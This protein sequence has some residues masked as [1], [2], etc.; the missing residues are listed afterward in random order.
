MQ[1]VGT[2]S[3]VGNSVVLAARDPKRSSIFVCMCSYD[4]SLISMIMKVKRH[5][6]EK[7]AREVIH[8]CN[9]QTL[10]L[11]RPCTV[12][13]IPSRPQQT[14]KLD[15]ITLDPGHSTFHDQPGDWPVKMN[16]LQGAHSLGLVAPIDPFTGKP[17]RRSANMQRYIEQ[18]WQ[19][20]AAGERAVAETKSA[21]LKAAQQ[22]AAEQ[23][24]TKRKAEA[25][26]KLSDTGDVV[27]HVSH[28]Y[29]T[30]SIILISYWKV[31]TGSTQCTLNWLT[32]YEGSQG[33]SIS[34]AQA[35]S[36]CPNA[37]PA[38]YDRK[39][40]RTRYTGRFDVKS[41]PYSHITANLATVRGSPPHPRAFSLY[42]SPIQ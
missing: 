30:K 3:I 18:M 12:D 9:L 40:T 16:A 6:V 25:S 34:L 20:K 7:L 13:H 14:L 39:T 26:V 1:K 8:C 42:A 27:N 35:R 29:S 23:I 19:S 24:N 10:A 11:K 5:R 31:P 22:K 37:N 17:K 15:S 32:F 41:E 28:S 4:S 21:E 33:S 36:M 38:I 2:N